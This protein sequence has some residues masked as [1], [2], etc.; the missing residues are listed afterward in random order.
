MLYRCLSIVSEFTLAFPKPTALPFPWLLFG[1]VPNRDRLLIALILMARN[2]RG[3]L[4]A[5]TAR[6]QLNSY[7]R[8]LTN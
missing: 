2:S 4:K 3:R 7:K 1:L 5:I 6:F 8:Q